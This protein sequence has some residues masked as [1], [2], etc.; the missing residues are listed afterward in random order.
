VQITRLE[1][2]PDRSD[3]DLDSIQLLKSHLKG[4]TKEQRGF[5]QEYLAKMAAEDNPSM[6]VASIELDLC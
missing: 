2:L 5:L 3:E 1:A 6:L 4:G